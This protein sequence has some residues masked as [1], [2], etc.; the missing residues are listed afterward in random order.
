MIKDAF[1]A[2]L[3]NYTDDHNNVDALWQELNK[4]YAATGRHYH[5]IIHLNNLLQQLTPHA[6][7]FT[8]WHVV[9]LAIAYHDAIYNVLKKNNEEK[10][11]DLATTR[12]GT[13]L[14]SHEIQACRQLILATKAHETSTDLEVN[15]FTDA[16]LSI[17]GAPPQIYNTYTLQ[18]RKEYSIYPDLVYNPGRKKV[19]AHFLNMA[20]IFKSEQ[21]RSLYE[22]QARTNLQE[23]LAILSL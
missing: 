5:T 15:L 1:Y 11:A 2:C 4:K 20:S 14:P 18:I 3:K 16:D 22:K 17:L 7:T 6:S 12:L 9:V 13:I 8:N 21:F 19:L 23:E 10:S